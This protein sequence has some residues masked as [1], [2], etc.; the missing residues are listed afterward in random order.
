MPV[1]SSRPKQG[2]NRLEDSAMPNSSPSKLEDPLLVENPLAG[3]LKIARM[4]GTT[5]D[6]RTIGI[7]ERPNWSLD[8]K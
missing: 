7:Q 3:M 1:K 4:F 6:E 2:N 8:E 5:I